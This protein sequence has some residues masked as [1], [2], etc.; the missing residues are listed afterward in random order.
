MHDTK[1]E[2]KILAGE[3][4]KETFKETIFEEKNNDARKTFIA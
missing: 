1:G 4:K 2:R 3:T